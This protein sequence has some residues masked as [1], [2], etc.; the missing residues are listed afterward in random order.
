MCQE[1]FI[2][3]IPGLVWDAEPPNSSAHLFAIGGRRKRAIFFIC[4][5]NEVG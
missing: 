1:L 2:K 4:S 3:Q 5:V